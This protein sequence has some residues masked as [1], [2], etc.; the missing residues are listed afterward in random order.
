MAQPPPLA[1]VTAGT[2]AAELAWK[3]K[4]D[5]QLNPESHVVPLHGLAQTNVTSSVDTQLFETQSESWPQET[6]L[7]TVPAAGA[8][9]AASASGVRT[10]PVPPAHT[11]ALYPP[12]EA[13]CMAV[14]MSSGPHASNRE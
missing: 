9:G 14:V 3:Q 12:I 7:A 13:A 6:P 4:P 1:W 5:S 10:G 8:A 2:A 11:G